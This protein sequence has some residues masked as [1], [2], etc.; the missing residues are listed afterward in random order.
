M[1]AKSDFLIK[2]DSQVYRLDR[3]VV[4]K[5]YRAYFEKKDDFSEDELD[6]E[7]LV[8]W[9]RN[10]MNYDEFK[11]GLTLLQNHKLYNTPMDWCNAEVEAEDQ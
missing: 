8:D 1:T 11:H 6:D 10:S 9:F 7:N 4:E 5:S 3:S 2:Q